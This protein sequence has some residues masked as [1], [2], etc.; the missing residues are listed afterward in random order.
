M[1]KR[2][3]GGRGRVG[4]KRREGGRVKLKWCGTHNMLPLEPIN[5]I[6]VRVCLECMLMEACSTST[7]R[8]T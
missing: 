2:K 7:A 1:G 4:K 3:E 5:T 8:E 6:R